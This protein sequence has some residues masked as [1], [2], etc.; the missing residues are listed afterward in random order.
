MTSESFG[1]YLLRELFWELAQ[2]EVAVPGLTDVPPEQIE[3]LA[4]SG[5][6]SVRLKTASQTL[7]ARLSWRGDVLPVITEVVDDTGS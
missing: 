4:Y 6:D 7:E 1:R 2:F 5:Y 3:V